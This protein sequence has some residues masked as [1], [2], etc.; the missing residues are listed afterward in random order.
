MG[1]VKEFQWTNPHT[2]VQLEVKNEKGEVVGQHQGIANYTI[3][4]RDK[5]GIAL[6]AFFKC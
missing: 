6:V 3:G 1:T 2:W 4:Q 5:L